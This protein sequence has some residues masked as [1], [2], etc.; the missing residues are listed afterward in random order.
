MSDIKQ[1]FEHLAQQNLLNDED[2]QAMTRTKVSFN[3]ETHVVRRLDYLASQLGKTRQA[4]V[5][6]IL[7]H[8]SM[9]ALVGYIGTTYNAS[10]MQ[11]SVMI[12]DIDQADSSEA[13]KNIRPR[14]EKELRPQIDIEEQIAQDQSKKKGGK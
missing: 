14:S 8:G 12:S 4:I 3:L 7:W 5:D 10:G 2:L 11:L 13:L 6:E 1:V 9:E